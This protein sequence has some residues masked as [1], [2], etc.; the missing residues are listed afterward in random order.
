MANCGPIGKS[1]AFAL[2]IIF[3][4]LY[5]FG[6]VHETILNY[7]KKPSQLKGVY[8]AKV[9]FINSVWAFLVCGMLAC[10][11]VLYT[12][13]TNPVFGSQVVSLVQ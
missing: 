13:G 2:K 4:F 3:K 8:M 7:H 9:M 12:E 1:S 5:L 10:T 6:E 11:A